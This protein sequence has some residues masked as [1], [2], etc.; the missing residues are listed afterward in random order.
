MNISS[1]SH[2]WTTATQALT[3]RGSIRPSKS[4]HMSP[5]R[6]FSLGILTDS[7]GATFCGSAIEGSSCVCV[8]AAVNQHTGRQ[9]VNVIVCLQAREPVTQECVIVPA[10]HSAPKLQQINIPL[11]LCQC[12]TLTH[13]RCKTQ[14]VIK[15]KNWAFLLF[16]PTVLLD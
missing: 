7:R 3:H 13:C 11:M 8:C 15:T 9:C 2:C 16:F 12:W 5:C 10:S 4:C 6:A 1:S 14:H